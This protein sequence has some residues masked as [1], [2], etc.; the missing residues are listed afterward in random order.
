M[1]GG[2][3]TLLFIWRL[4]IKKMHV[5]ARL[6]RGELDMVN[7]ICQVDWATVYPNIWSNIILGVSEGGFEY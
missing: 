6:I 3:M 2:I 4:W 5:A 7:F 1:F